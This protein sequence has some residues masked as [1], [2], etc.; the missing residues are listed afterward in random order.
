MPGP[1]QP[2]S[3]RTKHEGQRRT[4]LETPD[5]SE[6][7]VKDNLW[8]MLPF[9]EAT[10][11]KTYH[12]R[13]DTSANDVDPQV[14]EVLDLPVPNLAGAQEEDP[15]FVF[16]KELLWNHE[17]RPPLKCSLRGFRG[18][19]DTVDSISP[20][21]GPGKCS[22]PQEKRNNSQPPMASGGSH[23]SLIPDLQGLPSPCYGCSS[24]SS[25]NC[26]P[27]KETLLLAENAE[28]HGSLV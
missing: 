14:Q 13:A 12:I 9:A 19:K 27:D 6:P 22:I 25:E 28:R 7:E 20:A 3:V 24:G 5:R 21:E 15:D 10:W 18:S 17:I 4:D 23:A 16:V 1:T 2:K 26:C 11:R 8:A